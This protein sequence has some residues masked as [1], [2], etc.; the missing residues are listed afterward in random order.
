[1][2]V[3]ARDGE[4]RNVFGFD[5]ERFLQSTPRPARGQVGGPGICGP[6]INFRKIYIGVQAKKLLLR[7]RDDRIIHSLKCS[8]VSSIETITCPSRDTPNTITCP[9]RNTQHYH[10]ITRH[11]QHLITQLA[12]SHSPSLQIHSKEVYVHLIGTQLKF[13]HWVTVARAIVRLGSCGGRATN[14]C[15]SP[16]VSKSAI[17]FTTE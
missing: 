15:D 4:I 7:R 6:A 2:A 8:L 11:T 13:V 17:I 10:V 16:G 1:M 5:A 14:T 3:G 12:R 9:S